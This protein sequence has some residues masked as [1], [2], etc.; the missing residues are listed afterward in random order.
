MEEKLVQVVFA[1]S[2]GEVVDWFKTEQWS[3]AL[4]FRRHR[5]G[6]ISRVIN[7]PLGTV[8]VR[9][10]REIVRHARLPA[11]LMAS[12]SNAITVAAQTPMKNLQLDPFWPPTGTSLPNPARNRLFDRSFSCP[13]P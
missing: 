7:L 3:K 4:I 12:A 5:S 6:P 1:P 11:M 10:S 8:C 13:L 9:L 2:S